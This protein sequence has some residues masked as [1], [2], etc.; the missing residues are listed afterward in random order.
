MPLENLGPEAL[1][2]LFIALTGFL[3]LA[4]RIVPRIGQTFIDPE[5]L[6]RRMDEGETLV[7][8]DV[9]TPQEFS[10]KMGHVPGAVNLPL[11]H[12]KARLNEIR[13]DIGPYTEQPVFV[14]CRF[15]SQSPRAAKTLK[16]E[17][18]TNV[19]IVKGGMIRWYRRNLEVEG[20]E[21]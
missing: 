7:V 6:K 9:R 1:L 15:E 2:A 19:S 5:E 10:S 4:Q 21:E 16:K 8:L 11:K 17:G 18:F 13:D 3:L 12:F 14:V 20:K